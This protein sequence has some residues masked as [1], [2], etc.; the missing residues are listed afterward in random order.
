[1]SW[2]LYKEQCGSS[3]RD[4]DKVVKTHHYVIQA[5]HL[6]LSSGLL[7]EPPTI[8]AV[9]NWYTSVTMSDYEWKRAWQNLQGIGQI[10]IKHSNS[11]H[12][13]S[14]W[15]FQSSEKLRSWT[16]FQ[17][18]DKGVYLNQQLKTGNKGFKGFFFCFWAH[19]DIQFCELQMNCCH[20]QGIP[21]NAI[22]GLQQWK[23]WCTLIW[24]SKMLLINQRHESEY[25][26]TE[27]LIHFDSRCAL[28]KESK[29]LDEDAVLHSPKAI[30]TARSLKETG[31]C[32][33]NLL[34]RQCIKK[35][36]LTGITFWPWF[37]FLHIWLS[38]CRD[39]NPPPQEEH[40]FICLR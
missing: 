27:P 5:V 2:F 1:M 35:G 24:K 6:S 13:D 34:P 40:S 33:C 30:R 28:Q 21:K 18:T 8:N 12:L 17:N 19:L 23:N 15:I 36:N 11:S 38:E 25:G 10:Q 31:S 20:T 29:K 14:G 32:H 9:I 22:T 37:R 39:E 16:Y 3:K 7:W 26:V 4:T